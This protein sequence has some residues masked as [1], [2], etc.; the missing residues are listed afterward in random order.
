[1]ETGLGLKTRQIDSTFI[2]QQT[3]E[4]IFK[5]GEQLDIPLVDGVY[6]STLGPVFETPA[7]I[8]AFR[9]LGADLVGMSTVPEVTVAHHCGMRVAVLA[10]ISN[11]AAGMLDE[12]INH[13]RSLEIVA[14]ATENLVSLM[15]TFIEN[16]D[17]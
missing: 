8:R 1:M 13:E 12:S 16:N 7:E 4:Q 6:M 2:D 15:L 17:W 3:G 11:M 5:V 14:E 10:V 9:T